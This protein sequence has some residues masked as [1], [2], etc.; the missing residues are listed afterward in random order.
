[1]GLRLCS[2]GDIALVMRSTVY[3]YFVRAPI[4]GYAWGDDSLVFLVKIVAGFSHYRY[5]DISIGDS[6]DWVGDDTRWRTRC[7]SIVSSLVF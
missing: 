7:S 3:F 1:M 6:H 4:E 2:S 5:I